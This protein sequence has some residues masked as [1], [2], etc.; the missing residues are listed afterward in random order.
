M[1]DE[2]LRRAWQVMEPAEAQRVR[3]EERVVAAWESRSRS[4]FAEW[5]DVLRA[6][7]VVNAA[8]VLAAVAILLITTPIGGLLA[9]IPRA[10]AVTTVTRRAPE[11]SHPRPLIA[12]SGGAARRF[13]ATPR[14]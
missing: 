13:E 9:V 6:R 1:S 4:L 14:E 3:V 2:R 11:R 10:G 12:S 8:W 7:P 5:L